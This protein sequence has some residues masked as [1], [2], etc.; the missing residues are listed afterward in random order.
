MHRSHE[1]HA[2][3]RL[4]SRLR[5]SQEALVWLRSRRRCPCG[6]H[7]H[8]QQSAAEESTLQVPK[9]MLLKLDLGGLDLHV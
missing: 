7:Y 8:R 9:L 5:L 2:R 3:L 1:F 6:L 4:T